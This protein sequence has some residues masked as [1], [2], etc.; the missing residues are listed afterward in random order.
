MTFIGLCISECRERIWNGP[1]TEVERTYNGIITEPQR[2]HLGRLMGRGRA[3]LIFICKVTLSFGNFQ[4]RM[5]FFALGEMLIWMNPCN[6][7]K[8]NVISIRHNDVLDKL[9]E[10]EKK[11]Y[12]LRQ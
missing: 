9:K 1:E 6:S 3:A 4:I 5:R 7:L 12:E 10:I 2:T 11:I 8:D